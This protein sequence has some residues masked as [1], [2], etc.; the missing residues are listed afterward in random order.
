LVGARNTKNAFK[1]GNFSRFFENLTVN[2]VSNVE[3]VFKLGNLSRFFENL[4]VNYVSD[5]ENALMSK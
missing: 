3:N 2:S 5:V 4:T 1:L